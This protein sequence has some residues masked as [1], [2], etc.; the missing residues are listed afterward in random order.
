[1]VVELA[2]T[3]GLAVVAVLAVE[4]VVAVGAMEVVV[5]VAVLHF[6]PFAI[7]AASLQP[8]IVPVLLSVA[9]RSSFV[10]ALSWLG[11]R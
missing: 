11:P 1:M 10:A 3:V 7:V 2:A 8:D 9:H 6:V 4:L 5:L